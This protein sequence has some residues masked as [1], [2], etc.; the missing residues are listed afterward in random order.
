M[1]NKDKYFLL[2]G[3][4]NPSSKFL[5]NFI[6][7]GYDNEGNLID[8]SDV[9]YI[10]LKSGMWNININPQL[11]KN[12][13]LNVMK[14]LIEKNNYFS[15][16]QSVS[17]PIFN[18]VAEKLNILLN[19][20]TKT[21]NYKIIFS[22]SGSESNEIALK[23]VNAMYRTTNLL[24]FDMSYH[25]AT[26]NASLVSG[27]DSKNKIKGKNINFINFPTCLEEE[28]ASLQQIRILLEDLSIGAFIIEPVLASAGVYMASKNYYSNLH[29]LLK[30][31]NIIIIFDEVATGF[32]RTG[33]P[34]YFHQL[35][36]E[37]DIITMS[38][39][40]NN[41][42]IPFGAVAVN[43]DIFNKVNKASLEHFMT[44][45]GNLLG[46][47]TA[48]IVL[49]YYIEHGEELSENVINIHKVTNEI[50]DGALEYRNIG[51]ML[52]I[53]TGPNNPLEVMQSLQRFGIITYIYI[54]STSQGISIFP[55]LTMSIEKYTSTLKFIKRQLEK[56]C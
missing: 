32:Y 25:G 46:L 39:A 19:D 14:T 45:N 16:I 43:E 36:I 4:S 51:A 20:K 34:F 23:F 1:N 24:A 29:S 35:D 41:G 31:K 10:D 30:E 55:M 12:D 18:I 40:I 53:P 50:L 5:N 2:N 54:N 47:H 9:N 26:A 8:E 42:I 15:D 21:T 22:N 56:L 52:A 11:L 17:N 44:Q 37:P 48:N 13:V 33:T 28:E 3:T 6:Q 38:K 27:I 49:D 7:K